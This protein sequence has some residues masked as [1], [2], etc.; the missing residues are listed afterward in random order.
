[1]I[2]HFQGGPLDGRSAN[3]GSHPGAEFRHDSSET[4]GLTVRWNEP[5]FY[6]LAGELAPG[7]LLYKL[8]PTPEKLRGPGRVTA[9]APRDVLWNWSRRHDENE[10]PSTDAAIAAIQAADRFLLGYAYYGELS[11]LL[12]GAQGDPLLSQKA[13]EG[14]FPVYISAADLPKIIALIKAEDTMVSEDITEAEEA[15]LKRAGLG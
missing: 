9:L 7:E 5:A 6:A 8:A 13:S 10:P 12:L 14:L 2:I 11:K 3:V 4:D 15:I 1:M